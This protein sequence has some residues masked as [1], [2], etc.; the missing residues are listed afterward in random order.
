[1]TPSRASGP[2]DDYRQ[3]RD[4]VR[5]QEPAGAEGAKG[6]GSGE[7]GGPRRFVIH[8]H[9][10]R[11]LHWDLR[12]ERDGVLA[13]W[14]L[15]RGIPLEPKVNFIAPHTEDHPLEYLEFAGEIPAGSYGAGTISIW[16]HGT[17]ETLKWE[18][19]KV[20]VALHGERI[21]GRYALFAIGKEDEPKDWMIHRMD[22]PADATAEPMPER[23]VPMLARLA[24]LPR[25]DAGWSYEV[26]WDGVRALAYSEPGRLRFEGRSGSDI[27][28][29]Y[30][31]LGRL[32]RALR[33]HRALLDGEIVR[34]DETGRPSFAALQP[35]IGSPAAARRLASTA[36][37]TY[38]I[39]DLLWLDGHSLMDRPYAERRQALVDLHLDGYHWLTPR[40][41][42][43]AGRDILEASRAAGLEGVV[44]KRVDSRYR[45][46]Q[47]DGSWLKIKNTASQELVVG[48]WTPGSGRRAG[49]IGALLLGTYD[50]T[51]ALRYAGR[52]GSGFT[53]P[54]LEKLQG[55]LTPLIRQA[56]PFAPGPAKPPRTAKF[57]EP[58]LVVEVEFREWTKAGALRAPVYKG[59]R[60]DKPAAQVATERAPSGPLSQGGRSDGDHKTVIRRPDKL[61][62]PAAGLTKRGVVDYYAAIAPVLL[63]HLRDRPLTVKRYP[64]GVEGKAFFEKNSPSHRPGWVRTFAVPG[65]RSASI[66]Y[67][68]V[69]DLDTLLWLANLAAL[70]LHVPLAVAA[71]LARPGAVVFDLDPGPPATI[72]ECC[73]VALLLEGTFA[74]LGLASLAKTSGSKGLQV[75]VPLGGDVTYAQ[76]KHFSS[77]LAQLLERAQPD[78]VVSRM[79][80]SLRP[81]KVLID[82]SQNDPHKTTIC[83][84]SLRATERPTVS[85]PVS[86]DEVRRALDSGDPRSLAFECDEVLER[87]ARD[88]DLFAPLL[89]LEQSL[90]AV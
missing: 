76:T 50:A 12:L 15:P 17:Y 44:A 63:P 47:R 73:R 18:P 72:V 3:R 23:V 45:P 34:F 83:V 33:S 58:E 66:S 39:F 48:G 21:N 31:E 80:R 37:V 38:V 84:Y 53:G 85:T 75:Y 43:G 60:T 26:K 8:E 71:D 7:A 61:L 56:S 68:V 49:Q 27:T 6:E 20:E 54:E 77:S 64:D 29:L 65:G 79:A 30:P 40:P 89:A 86:W 9:S 81:G 14:A 70:E 88:G 78:L 22:P 28:G 36:P 35:R 41:L 90:P 19:R 42:E 16:D 10:A 82:W 5:T 59:L 62:Y 13:S 74:Q 52:V 69:D 2:L 87:V 25:D 57:V 55:L 4:F 24:A 11:R 32:T 46:G 1:V 51:G 67:T